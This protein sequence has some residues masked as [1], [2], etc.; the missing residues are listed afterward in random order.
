VSVSTDRS[1]RRPDHPH[2]ST[3][4]ASGRGGTGRIP[5]LRQASRPAW[6]STV[7]ASSTKP[8]RSSCSTID[9]R[10]ITAAYAAVSDSKLDLVRAEGSQESSYHTK[11]DLVIKQLIQ[12]VTD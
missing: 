6:R 4:A 2:R 5:T 10:D 11:P 1:F 7:T 8:S 3:D 9:H 12:H